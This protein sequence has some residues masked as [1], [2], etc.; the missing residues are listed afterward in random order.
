M[1][2]VQS[3]NIAVGKQ[4]MHP[5][6]PQYGNGTILEI[7]ERPVFE[8]NGGRHVN[9]RFNNGPTVWLRVS[10][11]RRPNTSK[12]VNRNRHISNKR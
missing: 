1:Y 7:A 12:R 3:E 4:V 10:E 11:V 9:V 6:F 2:R 8:P 5:I